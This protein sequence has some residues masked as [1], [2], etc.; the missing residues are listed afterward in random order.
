MILGADSVGR[1]G[2]LCRHSGT[3]KTLLARATAN[4]AGVPF[5]SVSGSEFSQPLVG[6]GKVRERRGVGGYTPLTA[7]QLEHQRGLGVGGMDAVCCA[8]A[9]RP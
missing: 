6:A 4:E 1:V 9:L 7:Q 3:G 8:V 2:V 5:F